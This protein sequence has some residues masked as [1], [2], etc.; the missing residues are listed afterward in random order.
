MAP[1]PPLFG[2]RDRIGLSAYYFGYFAAVGFT[3][4]FLPLFWR[5]LNFSYLQIGTLV[6]LASAAGAASL[7]PIG[8][9]SDRYGSRHP[10]IVAGSIGVAVCYLLYPLAH[11]FAAY[12]A[13][14]ALVG[15][16]TTMSTAIAAALGA[17]LFQ[18]AREGRS[19]ASVRSWGTVGFLITMACARFLPSITAG[20]TFFVIAATLHAAAAL[21]VLMVQRPAGELASAR[22]DFQ[23]VGAILSH[24]NT[25]AFVAVYLLGY[26]SLMPATGNLSLYLNSFHPKPD[27]G[28]IPLAYAISAGCELPFLMG[29]GWAADR[30]GR[31]APMRVCF[32][33]LPIRLALYALATVP[34]TALALQATHGLTFSVLAIVPFAFMADSTPPRYRATG[35][36]ILN[37]AGAAAY[38]IGPLVAGR[39]ADTIGIRSLYFYLAGIALLGAFILF[40]LVREP[41]RVTGDSGLP[42]AEPMP[43]PG[44]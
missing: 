9:L 32:L 16:G 31:M 38:A 5:E 30:F 11:T 25:L 29:M 1:V 26:M 40:A 10:F 44:G 33:V 2:P 7:V 36:A 42:L 17:D 13:L 43:A 12:A 39:V 8:A 19:F 15:V 20:T 27:P 4:P 28:V 22:L 14:Q 18:R 37:A 41:R 21:S 35:Q 34:T 6:A 3:T 23:G 24:R